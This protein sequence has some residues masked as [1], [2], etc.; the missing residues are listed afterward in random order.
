MSSSGGVESTANITD[1][2]EPL[3]FDITEEQDSGYR[4]A[5]VPA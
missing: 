1:I 5:F 4:W 3:H 2:H